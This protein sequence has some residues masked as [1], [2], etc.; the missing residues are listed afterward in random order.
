MLLYL[1]K[2]GLS[3]EQRQVR[4]YNGRYEADIDITVE[5]W[6]SMLQNRNIFSESA[7]DMVL[8]LTSAFLSA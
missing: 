8:N 7:L 4:Y 3:M 2:G 1:S 5:E 6:K